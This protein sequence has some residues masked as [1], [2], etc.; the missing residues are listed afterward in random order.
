MSKLLGGSPIF[1]HLPAVYGFWYNVHIKKK[2]VPFSTFRCR[3]S[4]N[5]NGKT[6]SATK[7]RKTTMSLLS[8]KI[9]NQRLTM[10]AQ[11]KVHS[12]DE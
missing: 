11:N 6:T 7:E 9:A 1:W 4:E 5:Q 8:N 10:D 2:F 3:Q 12:L